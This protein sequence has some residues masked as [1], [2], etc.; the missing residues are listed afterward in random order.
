MLARRWSPCCPRQE[1]AGG[2]DTPSRVSGDGTGELLPTAL[3][4][5]AQEGGLVTSPAAGSQARSW[6]HLHVVPTGHPRILPV[7][8]NP[9]KIHPWEWQRGC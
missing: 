4:L 2:R 7:Q 8:P 9:R 6:T 3:A 5:V 1:H